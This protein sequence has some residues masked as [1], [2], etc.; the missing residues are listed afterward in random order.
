M[1]TES[2]AMDAVLPELE[3]H[4]GTYQIF[5][6]LKTTRHWLDLPNHDRLAFF[7][8]EVL[9]ILKRRPQVTFRYFESE[10]FHAE[11]S[12]ILVW[13]TRDLQAWAWIADH[14]RETKFWDHYFQ[15]VQILPAVEAD[16]FPM[17]EAASR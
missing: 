11:T 7:R 15:V 8:D 10:A 9:P 2:L 16:Y 3:K 6:H 14:L 1:T 13:E 12:D 4:A 17:M 5:M